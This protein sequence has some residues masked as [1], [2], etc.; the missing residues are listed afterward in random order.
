MRLRAA[1]KVG[2]KTK[3]AKKKQKKALENR[4]LT[5]Q[6]SPPAPHRGEHPVISA[7]TPID[8]DG[9]RHTSRP[10]RSG[11]ALPSP[12]GG[13]LSCSLRPSPCYPAT[14]AATSASCKSDIQT[15][16]QN[17][18]LF[19]Y[20]ARQLTIKDVANHAPGSGGGSARATANGAERSEDTGGGETGRGGVRGTA[21]TKQI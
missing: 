6:P 17:R 10:P 16:A 1:T 18:T 19:F 15:A 8:E 4:V 5:R 7:R 11:F 14:P 2:K 3:T 12:H 9:T 21:T 20:H 13:D